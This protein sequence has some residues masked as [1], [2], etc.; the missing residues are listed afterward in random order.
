[1]M[2]DYR[3]S[4]LKT[5]VVAA[6]L[7]L[8]PIVAAHLA[9]SSVGGLRET[10][11]AVSGW[12][13]G[14]PLECLAL[15]G[16]IALYRDQRERTGKADLFLAANATRSEDV[17]SAGTVDWGVQVRRVLRRLVRARGPLVGDTVEIRS[18]AEIRG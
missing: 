18:L 12:T 10:L 6:A 14:L 1:M 17:L 9:A 2:T 11:L 8:A 15:G 3:W 7:G 16:V 5:T 13:L 4:Y